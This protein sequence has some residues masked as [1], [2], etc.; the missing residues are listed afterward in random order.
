MLVS[1][2]SWSSNNF[3]EKTH[4]TITCPGKGLTDGS[5]LSQTLLLLTKI[6]LTD[7]FTGTAG[8]TEARK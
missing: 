7:H 1:G 6:R 4:I 3:M 8:E 5:T 2:L